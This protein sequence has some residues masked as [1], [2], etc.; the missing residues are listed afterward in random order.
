VR[1]SPVAALAGA[2][3]FITIT[4]C[5]SSHPGRKVQG[6]S[7]QSQVHT[8]YRLAGQTDMS[9]V[10]TDLNQ[11]SQDVSTY[12]ASALVIVGQD[13]NQLSK[14]SGALLMNFPPACMPGDVPL[15]NA[16]HDYRAAATA[17]GDTDYSRASADIQAGNAAMSRASAD[18][19]RFVTGG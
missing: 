12:G 10:S 4:G 14:D 9:A 3:I 11:V 15:S 1:I 13:L 6:P 18:V 8:W 2:A 7:C 17:W 5:S 16:L 19:T